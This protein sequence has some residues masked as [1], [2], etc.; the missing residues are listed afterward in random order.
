MG[1]S[2]IRFDDAH[3]FS[4]AAPAEQY[5]Y[6]SCSP[7][8]HTT[9]DNDTAVSEWLSFVQSQGIERVCCLIAGQTAE[10]RR[11]TFVDYYDVFGPANVCHA[12]TVDNR[13][14]D[15]ETLVETILPFLAESVAQQSPVVV[16]CLSG[17]GRTGQVLASWLVAAY[18]YTP[19]EAIETVQEMGR[20]PTAALERE[21][22]TEEDL[23]ALLK[24]VPSVSPR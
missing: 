4:P 21:E 24:S 15:R 17:V 13:L 11:T 20:D 16:H 5:V 22:T 8:W 19:E 12:P 7:Y 9:A 10:I 2:G 3:R 23:Y 14:I 1:H 6:G 18:E